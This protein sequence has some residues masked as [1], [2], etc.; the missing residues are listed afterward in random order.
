LHSLI[1]K[2]NTRAHCTSKIIEIS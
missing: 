1:V 2:L